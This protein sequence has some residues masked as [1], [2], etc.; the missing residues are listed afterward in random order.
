M[1]S[2]SAVFI[3]KTGLDAA[4]V[5]AL[6]GKTLRVGL[7]DAE[8]EVELFE[9]KREGVSAV[10]VLHEDEGADFGMLKKFAS[11]LAVELGRRTWMVD[12]FSNAD[13]GCAA[14]AFDKHGKGRWEMDFSREV[15][16]SEL[17]RVRARLGVPRLA[18]TS[19]E[20]PFW[21]I[22]SEWKSKPKRDLFGMRDS[23]VLL[24]SEQKWK[25]VHRGVPSA[26]GGRRRAVRATAAR[27]PAPV[28]HHGEPELRLEPK[29][30]SEERWAAVQA[31][32]ETRAAL[33]HD[34]AAEWKRRLRERVV[35]PGPS[36]TL[37]VP[38]TIVEPARQLA[39][40]KQVPLEW[41]LQQ[42]IWLA[43]TWSFHWTHF[44]A[45][46]PVDPEPIELIVA[47]A[48]EP[49][50]K[51][52]RRPDLEDASFEEMVCLRLLVGVPR[53]ALEVR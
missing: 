4:Q 18:P 7:L 36:K 5:L 29:L 50:L 6:L 51:S 16:P 43:R 10:V 21:R 31:A 48:L 35:A 34:D 19:D 39:T 42:A 27:A 45:I 38:K 20:L 15:A 24:L 53:L 2:G 28:P 37:H 49:A 26:S 14:M 40:R 33:L 23:Q 17:E 9:R 1:S 8:P 44:K 3:E 22:V 46:A 32:N 12:V 30:I 47:P 25:L 41:V 52:V 11:R 13:V